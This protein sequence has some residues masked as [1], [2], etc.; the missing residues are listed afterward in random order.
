ML[1]R[2]LFSA[3]LV[4]VMSLASPVWAAP[5][6]DGNVGGA[7][8]VTVLNDVA[9]NTKDFF[10]TGLDIDTL[11]FDASA[12]A[13]TN[14]YWLAMTAV[15]PPVD[16]NGDPTSLLF[17]S[18]FWTIFY[19]NAGTTPDYMVVVDM[20]GGTPDLT[21]AEWNGGGWTTVALAAADYDISLVN[22]LELRIDQVKMPNLDAA[23]YVRSQLDG[24][25]QWDDDQLGGVVP[26]PATIALMGLGLAAALIKRRK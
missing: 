26:E 1:N 8:Y 19:D 23:P 16:S 13:G 21:L 7:E 22:A 3:A 10:N 11:H 4:G 14:W 2:I 6:I 12:D 17:K 9:E 15:N 25:G 24:T 20:A 5:M 18:I